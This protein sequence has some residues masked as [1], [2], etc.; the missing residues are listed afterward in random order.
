MG[1][2]ARIWW[3]ASR[4]IYCVKINGKQIRLSPDKKEAERLFHKLMVDK[5]DNKPAPQPALLVCEVADKFIGWCRIHREK[6]TADGYQEHWE[7][8]LKWLPNGKTMLASEFRPFHVIEYMDAHDWGA[9]YK[10]NA[11][12]SIQRAFKWAVS[13]GLLDYLHPCVSIPKPKATRRETPVTSAEYKIIMEHSDQHFGDVVQF[14]WETSARPF[15]IR[16]L[17]PSHVK[18]DDNKVVFP[19][20]ESK[21]KRRSRIV[22]LNAAARDILE[23]RLQSNPQWVFTNRK[24]RQWTIF[25]C[26]CRFRTL[27]KYVGRKVAL[28]DCRHGF[29]TRKLVEGHSVETVAALMGHQSPQMLHTVYGHLDKEEEH[30]RKAIQ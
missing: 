5:A 8:F 24:G 26:N 11:A 14:A 21:G 28:Y 27:T 9:C 1:R 17:Q 10:R 15:E 20:K 25:A 22:Y 30:L 18:L 13:V 2:K 6:R 19:I 23:R 29:G 4:K 3:H 7:L 16:N 12:A